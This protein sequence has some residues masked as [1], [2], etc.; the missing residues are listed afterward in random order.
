M[1]TRR[2][3]RGTLY[4]RITA[5]VRNVESNSRTNTIPRASERLHVTHADVDDFIPYSVIKARQEHE[6]AMLGTCCG[7]NEVHQA[8]EPNL[9]ANKESKERATRSKWLGLYSANKERGDGKGPR[10]RRTIRRSFEGKRNGG[11]KP[12]NTKR[13]QIRQLRDLPEELRI[14]AGEQLAA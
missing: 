9:E 3:A 11:R 2:E 8:L 4:N 1:K 5:S 13:E 12:R 10:V 7:T 14:L 6:F